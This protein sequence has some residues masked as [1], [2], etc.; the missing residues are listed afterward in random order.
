MFCI[1]IFLLCLDEDLFHLST[2][3][4]VQVENGGKKKGNGLC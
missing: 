2:F 3:P 4:D 1:L